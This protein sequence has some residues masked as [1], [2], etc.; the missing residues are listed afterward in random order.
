MSMLDTLERKALFGLTRWLTLLLVIGLAAV[1]A[2]MIPQATESWR[3]AD[4]PTVDPEEVLAAATGA[5]KADAESGGET[6]ATKPVDA[7]STVKLPKVLAE[8]FNM[9]NNSMVLSGWLE[10]IPLENRQAF[11]DGMASAV[12]L[13]NARK[14]DAGVVIN[15]YRE[16]YF[17]QAGT[18]ALRK[19]AAEAGRQ[20]A[21]MI[22]G[23]AL[24]LLA[25]FSLV[26]VLLAIERNTRPTA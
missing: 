5:V 11:V 12:T 14:Q 23:A 18:L 15:Q 26:L 6:Q 21:M 20:Q 9:I 1:I 3:I 7:L 2:L 4:H 16:I 22:G 10:A 17:D 24:L 25:V 13:G 19:S 8:P